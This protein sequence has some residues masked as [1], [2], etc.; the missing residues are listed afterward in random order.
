MILSLFTDYGRIR[1]G[2]W[3]CF[4]KV[5]DWA[6]GLRPRPNTPGAH[7][8]GKTLALLL[9]QAGCLLRGQIA[10]ISKKHPR[11]FGFCYW[12]EAGLQRLAKICS[13]RAAIKRKKKEASERNSYLPVCGLDH[14]QPGTHRVQ[15]PSALLLLLE[16]ACLLRGHIAELAG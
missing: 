4:G 15:R 14:I 3:Q 11:H 10:N 16:R 1:Y 7:R 13:G 5:G 2:G 8:G 6:V 9:W 12:G